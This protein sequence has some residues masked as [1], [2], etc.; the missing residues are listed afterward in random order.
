[1]PLAI[2]LVSVENAQVGEEPV[3]EA[4]IFPRAAKYSPAADCAKPAE[5]PRM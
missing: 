5:I 3:G 1:M 2:A 4:G